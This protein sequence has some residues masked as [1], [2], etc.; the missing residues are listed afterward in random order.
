VLSGRG[1]CNGLIPRPE[2]SYRLWCVSECDQVK[3]KTLYTCCEQVGRRRKDYETTNIAGDSKHHPQALRK[4]QNHTSCS[5]LTHLGY[6]NVLLI[7]PPLSPCYLTSR[8]WKF[9][10][11]SFEQLTA[12]SGLTCRTYMAMLCDPQDQPVLPHT[13][14]HV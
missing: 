4:P 7:K 10:P 13:H 2:E 1:L 12:T 8:S 5:K 11:P 3:I 9:I 14:A 6:R